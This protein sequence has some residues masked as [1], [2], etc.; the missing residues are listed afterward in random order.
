MAA[1]LNPVSWMIAVAIGSATLIGALVTPAV[2]PAV[3]LGMIAPLA[4][5]TISWMI[6]NHTFRQDPV[7]L[8]GV[9]L[10]ALAMKALFFLA[11]V[12]LAIRVLQ[13]A[14]QPFVISFAAYFVA[15]YAMEAVFLR[16]LFSRAWQGARS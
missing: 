8:T 13:V 10:R 6:I 4:A 16:R 11:Y 1:T 3:V 9:M 2:R 5:A 15:L 12:A 14:P 7:R